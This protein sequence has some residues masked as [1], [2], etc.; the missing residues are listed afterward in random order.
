MFTMQRHQPS[1]KQ[2]QATTMIPVV[3]LFFK[4]AITL[5]AVVMIT[6]ANRPTLIFLTN[7]TNVANAFAVPKII[8]TTQHQR[9]VVRQLQRHFCDA[10][11]KDASCVSK[12]DDLMQTSSRDTIVSRNDVIRSAWMIS[13]MTTV[14]VTSSPLI[15]TAAES[16]TSNTIAGTKQDPKY[17]ACLSQCMY[18]CTKPKGMEQKS[19]AVCLPECKAQCATTKQQLMLGTPIK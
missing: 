13:W 1:Q 14:V 11:K 3:V 10:T 15:V 5:L 17:E 8:T 12:S 19:R 7:T 18:D 6:I 16:A 4:S 2:R 9:N